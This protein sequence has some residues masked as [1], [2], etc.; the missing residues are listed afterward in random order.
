MSSSSAPTAALTRTDIPST[1]LFSLA[2]KQAILT[3]ATRGIGK[4]CAVALAEA[5][6]SCCLVLRPPS[7]SNADSPT[8]T[9]SHSH[10]DSPQ[11]QQQ[12]QQHEALRDLPTD[13][14]QRHC[15]VYAD[16][17]DSHSVKGVFEAALKKDEVRG[18]V[19]ILVNVGGIQ[20]RNEAVDFAEEQ[21]DEVINVNLKT[22]WLLSQQAGKH[23]LSRPGGGKIINFGSLLTFQGGICIPAYASSKGAVGQLT[24]ALSN[25]WAKHSIQVNAIA[26]GYISTDMTEK[27]QQDPVRERQ[28]SERIPAGRWGTPRDFAGP[29]GERWLMR[30]DRSSSH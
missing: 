7:S 22:V 18:K 11:Q 4:G 25:E 19:D 3:G 15:I 26:P 23:F 28:I 24:K 13:Q 17:A 6:A 1:S 21:W 2:G 16:L 8:G 9:H 30:S 12:Q 5:G 27:L 20:R 10:S 29:I 14:G